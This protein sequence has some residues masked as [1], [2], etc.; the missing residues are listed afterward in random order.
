MNIQR[1][2]KALNVFNY[3]FWLIFNMIIKVRQKNIYQ[4]H[5][6]NKFPNKRGYKFIICN[7]DLYKWIYVP[8][9]DTPLPP[10]DPPIYNSNIKPLDLYPI[11]QDYVTNL[12]EKVF[13]ALI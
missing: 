12:K 5:L 3:Y 7:K 6:V 4:P 1:I 8:S 13:Y 11:P 9:K 10:Y 2:F